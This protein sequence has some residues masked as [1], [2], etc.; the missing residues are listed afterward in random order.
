MQTDR[1]VQPEPGK[2]NLL[3]IEL[4]PAAPAE[5]AALWVM[6]RDELAGQ[7]ERI[8]QAMGLSWAAFEALYASRGEVRT[9][10][11]AGE[12]VGYCW[13]EL[14]DR[15]LHL[16]ALFVLPQHRSRG[17]GTA[18]LGQLETMFGDR[19]DVIELGVAEDNPR[20]QV[21]YERCGFVA[22]GTLPEVG[23]AIMRKW[24]GGAASG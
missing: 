17:I 24:L 5:R 13:I 21:L 10:W 4:V 9:L 2:E 1:G 12:T 23:Y 19:V 3:E 18:A 14:R 16:H 7:F 6:M 8:A 20:A 11:C 22:E 15:E